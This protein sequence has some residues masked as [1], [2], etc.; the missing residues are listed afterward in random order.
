MSPRQFVD[1]FGAVGRQDE[2]FVL[3]VAVVPVRCAVHD[4]YELSGGETKVFGFRFGCW[5]AYDAL[6]DVA[7]LPLEVRGAT[8]GRRGALE[9]FLDEDARARSAFDETF[10]TQLAERVLDGLPGDAVALHERRD[11]RQLLS[12]AIAPAGDGFPQ[13]IGDFAAWLR[14]HESSVRRGTR[15]IV[16]VRLA[17][18]LARSY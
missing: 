2:G 9:R 14:W 11:A 13:V 7:R 5:P 8:S 10:A 16:L 18:V 1:E 15:R 3:E 4:E 17:C 6:S 12:R